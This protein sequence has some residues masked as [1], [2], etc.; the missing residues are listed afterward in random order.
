MSTD[1]TMAGAGQAK[2]WSWL[3]SEESKQF[4]TPIVVGSSVVHGF[5]RGSKELGIPTANLDMESLCNDTDVEFDT[6]IYFGWAH[7][8]GTIYNTV[9]SIGYNPVYNNSHKTIEAHLI[10]KQL[11]DFYGERLDLF[12]VGYLRNERNFSTLDDLISCIHADISYSIRQLELLENDS[13]INSKKQFWLK[14]FS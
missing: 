12:L 2:D 5:G 9:V 3:Y 13:G 14:K 8:N 6:G 1:N 4:S 11:D 10:N 7:L